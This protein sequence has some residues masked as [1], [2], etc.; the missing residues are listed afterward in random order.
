M[1]IIYEEHIIDVKKGTKVIDLLKDEISRSRYKVVACRFNNEVKSLNYEI[2]SDGKIELIDLTNKD[3]MRIYRR[4]L[5]YIIGKAFYET[6]KDAL[7]TINFQLSNSMLCE[8]SNMQVTKEMIE[9]VDKKVKEIIKRD[10]PIT[11]IA[12]TKE[13]AE[14]FYEKENTLKGRL[15]LDV[16]KKKEIMLYYCED[17]Y[18]Y[19]YG[20]MPI[21]TGVTD[22]YEILE[23]DGRFL[24]RYPSKKAPDRLPEFKENKKL[25]ATLDDYEEVHKTLNV[26]TLYKLNKI[27]KENKIKDYILLDEA[28]HEKKMAQIADDIVKREKVKVVLIAGPSSSGKTTFAKRLGLQ[29]RLNGLKPVTISVDNYFVER[30]LNPKDEYGNYDFECLEAID[31]DLFNDHILKLL[32]GEEIEVP[33]FDFEHG[34]KVYKGNT[35]KLNDDQILVIEGIHCL[36]DKLTP[37]IP[38]E[39]KYKVYI[40]ALTVLNIDY[41]NRISTTDTR[42]IR[43]IVRDNQFR[44]YSAL[45]TLKMWDSVNRGEEKNIFPYQEE[46]DS[47][48]N[49]SLIYELAVLKDYA[50]PLLEKI[51]KSHP[52]FSEAKRLYRMLG[53]FESIPGEYVPQ[54]SLLREFIGGSI[55]ED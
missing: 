30:T 31:I 12:M 10:A 47:M 51:D 41:Y 4:G 8:V 35:M 28:L 45:H 48:F 34:T 15:Q 29:L 5:I 52:E 44:S 38:K 49:S 25:L 16:K 39:Q 17:Y 3:G 11:K 23:Y 43:R 24:V 55:F 14:A 46:A 20:V 33:T 50:M 37:L 32:N 22:I 54:N 21:S 27:V 40:S 7:L 42:L 26:H 1:Q 53:Y 9:K 2:N 18:N 19:F 36:N 6:Y 13:E